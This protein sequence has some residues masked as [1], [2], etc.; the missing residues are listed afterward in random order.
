MESFVNW[1]A[2]VKDSLAC[3]ISRCIHASLFPNRSL[4][5]FF[6]ISFSKNFFN[7]LLKVTSNKT[8]VKGT[9]RR[10]VCILRTRMKKRKCLHAPYVN[11]LS[12][13]YIHPIFLWNVGY[14]PMPQYSMCFNFILSVIRFADSV[15][16]WFALQWFA[17][18]SSWSSRIR[19]KSSASKNKN[20]N[21]NLWC[22]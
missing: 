7:W 9:L 19:T 11:A 15:W 12:S 22:D 20:L 3:V 10:Q 6:F 4:R 2:F 16:I 8:M 5:C 17:R 14:L 21:R 13:S 1:L 18:E